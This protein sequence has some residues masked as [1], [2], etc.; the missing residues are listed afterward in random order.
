MGPRRRRQRRLYSENQ[1]GAAAT[2]SPLEG[3]PQTARAQQQLDL[4]GE[5]PLGE[6]ALLPELAGRPQ[7]GL[8]RRQR[9]ADGAR[10][11]G[12]QVQGHVL[13]ALVQLPQ[14]LLLLLVPH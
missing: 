3:P 11:L 4:D 12:P 2:S 14:V 7:R 1:A 6:G 10:L 8:V 9:L 13:L 5:L